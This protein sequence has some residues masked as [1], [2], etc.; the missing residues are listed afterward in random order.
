[1]NHAVGGVS[2][3]SGSASKSLCWQL[4]SISVPRPLEPALN[5]MWPKYYVKLDQMLALFD[6]MTLTSDSDYGQN[7]AYTS[8]KLPR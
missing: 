8:T 7:R 5:L 2:C 4:R 1:L 3:Y 6:S